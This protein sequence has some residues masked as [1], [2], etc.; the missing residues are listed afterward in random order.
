MDERIE[1]ILDECIDAV[2]NGGVGIEDAI[3][4]YPGHEAG[5][6]PLVRLAVEGREALRV[7]IPRE[8]FYTTKTRVMEGVREA[9][10]RRN[11]EQQVTSGRS[12][13]GRIGLKP[14]AWITATF[15]LLSGG[16]ALAA[17]AAGP[18]SLLYPLKQRMEE[19]R[20][21]LIRDDLDKA[22]REAGY[23]GKRLDEIADMAAKGKPE[24]IPD[25]VY[26]YELHLDKAIG[27][28]NQAKA[29]GQDASEVYAMIDD[30]QERF[31]SLLGEIFDQLPEEIRRELFAGGASGAMAGS[32]VA[33]GTGRG[34]SP[35]GTRP[36]AGDDDDDRYET[37]SGADDDESEHDTAPSRPGSPGSSGTDDSHGSESPDSDG[38]DGGDSAS[39][40]GETPTDDHE[41]TDHD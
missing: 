5:L 25:L 39:S 8:S 22:R 37:P 29:D 40:H 34:S 23:A 1:D 21:S 17:S 41:E 30:L 6:E 13:R 28:A 20:T 16:T 27:Y 35:A 15:M 12:R 19:A 11:L 18:D 38:V 10:A 7:E 26:R 4:R 24:I 14:L 2:L 3:A 33:G 31:A 36:A 9:A 32:S